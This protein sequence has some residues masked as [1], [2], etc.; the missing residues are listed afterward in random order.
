VFHDGPQPMN[1][2][3]ESALR[4][5]H[6][7]SLLE[8]AEGGPLRSRRGLNEQ[9]EGR[10]RQDGTIPCLLNRLEDGLREA[11]LWQF[12]ARQ[13]ALSKRNNLNDFRPFPSSFRFF[14]RPEP[15]LWMQLCA[16]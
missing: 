1:L 2:I 6:L 11:G 9:A 5:S 10:C 12:H 14:M 8:S 3:K 16:C 13:P 4:V 15:R 7:N